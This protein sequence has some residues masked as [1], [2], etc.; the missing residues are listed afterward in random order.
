MREKFGKGVEESRNHESLQNTNFIRKREQIT[1]LAHSV[2]RMMIRS[3]S[4]V[5]SGN[6][7]S[8]SSRIFSWPS[9]L[10]KDESSPS[11]TLQTPDSMRSVFFEI[12]AD[13]PFIDDEIE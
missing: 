6:D 5:D 9:K 13:W 8:V 4:S 2:R 3:S 7:A 10:R 11:S 1:H 12:A